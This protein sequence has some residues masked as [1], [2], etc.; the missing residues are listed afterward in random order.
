MTLVRAPDTEALEDALAKHLAALGLARYT[1]D[2][3]YTAT[4]LPAIFFGKLPDKPD[5]AILINTYNE[6]RGRDQ[7][8]PDFYV[9]LRF[10]TA[11]RDKRTTDRLADTV[12]RELDDLVNDRS[13]QVWAGV[14]ILSCHRILRVPAA[15]D[16]TLRYERPDSYRI[17]TNP[18][19]IT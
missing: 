8:T 12:F 9:Q 14:N 10:R 7:S 16:T 3:I 18:G 19:A 5:T 17:T 2:G 11:G 4:G 6:D 13:N 15:Q 1:P